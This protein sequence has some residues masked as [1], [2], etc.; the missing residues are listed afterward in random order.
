MSRIIF[1]ILISSLSVIQLSGQEK[2]IHFEQK[3]KWEKIINK[4]KKN[5]KLIF[6]DCYTTWCIPC[7]NMS[8]EVFVSD[9]VGAYFNDHFINIKLDIEKDSLGAMFKRKFMISAVPTLL[10]IDPATTEVVHMSVGGL[11]IDQLLD[12]AKQAMDPCHNLK[13]LRD[14]YLR[15]EFDKDFIK[16]YLIT[17]L[18]AGDKQT[19]REVGE[20][21]VSSFTID[22]LKDP[23]NWEMLMMFCYDPLAAPVQSMIDSISYARELLGREKVDALINELY[24]YASYEISRWNPASG[25]IFDESRNAKI[26][27][28]LLK[29]D[30]PDVPGML[31]H[32]YTAEHVRKGNYRSMLDEM[33]NVMRFNMFQGD[34][35]N[36]Y[37][38]LFM[39]QLAFCADTLLL[40]EGIDWIDDKFKQTQNLNLKSNLMKRKAALLTKKGDSIAAEDAIVQSK[41]LQEQYMKERK[42]NR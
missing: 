19:R 24:Y 35:E 17:L 30:H 21:F 40:Q 34:K 2:G 4:A 10:F 18:F 39:D 3:I 9:S 16:E 14:R 23:E 31:A 1:V 28:N 32:L 27:S 6:V 25:D 12:V 8:T 36:T 29:F 20:K 11:K 37:F 13:G 38:H 42:N 26:V 33:H 15:G 7:K 22:E 41:R 5:N